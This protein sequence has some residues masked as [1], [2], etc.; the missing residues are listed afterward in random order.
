LIE[1]G[2]MWWDQYILRGDRPEPTVADRENLA[3]LWPG[4]PNLDPIT[5]DDDLRAEI[6]RFLQARQFRTN[7]DAVMADARFVIE[8]RLGDHT[9]VVDDQGHTLATWRPQ[10]ARRID[11]GL[12]RDLYPEVADAATRE[13]KSRVFRPKEPHVEKEAEG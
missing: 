11:T 9:E 1:F 12:I 13:I 6:K 10:V 4:D 5:A 2:G 8:K 7:A 3:R